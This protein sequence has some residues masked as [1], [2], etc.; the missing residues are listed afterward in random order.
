M[1]QYLQPLTVLCELEQ[2]EYADDGEELEVGRAAQ[3]GQ[4]EQVDVECEC[5]YRVYDVHRCLEVLDLRGTSD[6][7]HKDLEG[8]P[9]M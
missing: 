1:Q 2:P 5:G 8:E 3:R 6:E 9:E 7:S 4:N